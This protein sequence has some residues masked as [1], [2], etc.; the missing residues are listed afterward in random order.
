M[1]LQVGSEHV[2]K[3]LPVAILISLFTLLSVSFCGLFL[4]I[5]FYLHYE[6]CFSVSL[7]AW[8]ILIG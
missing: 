8:Y 4:L 5:D 7:Y 6:L 2:K 3:H 1:T